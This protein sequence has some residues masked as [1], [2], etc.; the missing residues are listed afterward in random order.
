MI[1]K[2]PRGKTRLSFEP[3][4]G[5]GY[6][7]TPAYYAKGVVLVQAPSTTGFKT[8]QARLASALGRYVNRERGYILS[9]AAA[10]RFMVL[11]ESGAD[12]SAITGTI[13]YSEEN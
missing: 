5:D 1:I 12:A 11:V 2:L 8:R 13:F 9:P 10:E 7:I 6:T 3:V 4:Q